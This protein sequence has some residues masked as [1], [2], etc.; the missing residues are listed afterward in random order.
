MCGRYPGG[1][2]SQ[3]YGMCTDSGVNRLNRTDSLQVCLMEG[4]GNGKEVRLVGEDMS[5][6]A[7]SG[8]LCI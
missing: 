6:T 5:P 3:I 4:F 7:M 1:I 8:A 2:L